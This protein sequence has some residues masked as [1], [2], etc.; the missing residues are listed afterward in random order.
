MDILHIALM[1]NPLKLARKVFKPKSIV[2]KVK[3]TKSIIEICENNKRT[4][5][6]IGTS[7]FLKTIGML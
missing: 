5:L 6:R 7:E 2:N 1:N 3:Q 4:S